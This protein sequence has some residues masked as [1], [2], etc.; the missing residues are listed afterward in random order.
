MFQMPSLLLKFQWNPAR[1]VI[2][3]RGLR[4]KRVR[5][6]LAKAKNAAKTKEAEAGNQEIDP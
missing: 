6:P 4:E 5:K 2:K 1:L 3:A